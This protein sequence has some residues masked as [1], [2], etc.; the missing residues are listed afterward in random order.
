MRI[1]FK[2][3]ECQGEELKKHFKNNFETSSFLEKS[4]SNFKDGVTGNLK[5]VHLN[6][7]YALHQKFNNKNLENSTVEIEQDEPS[8]LLQFVIDGKMSLCLKDHSKEKVQLKDNMYYLFYVP[9]STYSFQ[10]FTPKKN[11]LN[12]FFTKSFLEKKMG[13]DFATHFIKKVQAK[14]ENQLCTLLKKELLLNRK[15]KNIVGEYMNCSFK[16]TIRS[17]YLESKLTELLLIALMP[18]QSKVSKDTLN[19]QD[20]E[21][22]KNIENYIQTHLKNELTIEQLSVLAGFNTF[23]F[24]SVFKQV[25]GM[26]VFQYITSL[27]IEKAIQL[28]S[29]EGFTISQASYEVG[30]KNPQHFTVA[31]KK[32]LGYLPSQ[33]IK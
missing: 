2:S 6:N 15:L 31:F 10:Y 17:S 14:N 3:S 5:E 8:F 32:K 16:G 1:Q 19:K 7:L 18:N 21:V 24:K 11:I 25:Y 33:L 22:L 12:I 26:P 29:K 27:R 23:K 4:H 28:I 13:E 20:E 9:A 30:Y